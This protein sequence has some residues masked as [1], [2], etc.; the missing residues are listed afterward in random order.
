MSTTLQEAGQEAVKQLD[1]SENATGAVQTVAQ[2][3]Q[4]KASDVDQQVLQTDNNPQDWQA[5]LDYI[6]QLG[7]VI[8]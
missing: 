2:V 8:Y 4:A 7:V 1:F 3:V 5:L 6:H